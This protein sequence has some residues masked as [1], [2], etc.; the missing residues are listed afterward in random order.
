[1][2]LDAFLMSCVPV[3][4]FQTPA[5][6]MTRRDSVTRVQTLFSEADPLNC[7]NTVMCRCTDC[8]RAHATLGGEP[9]ITFRANLS[10][11]GLPR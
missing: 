3:H 4:S 11:A 5:K 8:R 10:P 9:E 7:F 1:M 2:L 6:W